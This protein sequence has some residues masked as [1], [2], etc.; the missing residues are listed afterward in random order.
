M[1][2]SKPLYPLIIIAAVMTKL[3]S[4]TSAYKSL[5]S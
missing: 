4:M 2:R 3:A 5:L 1:N